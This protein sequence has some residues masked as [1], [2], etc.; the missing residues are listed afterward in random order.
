M[1]IAIF[2]LKYSPNLG[3]GIIA[4]CLAH[5]LEAALP[6]ASVVP[7]DLAGRCDFVPEPDR[8]RA[9][10]L[11]VLQ[12]LPGSQRRLIVRRLLE[13]KIRDQLRPRWRETLASCD[14][15]V[16]GG[17]QLF[18]D[19]DLNFP[20]KLSAA[21][22]ECRNA[23]LPVA[24]FGVG[25]GNDWST[26][27]RRLL[28]SVLSS[29]VIYAGVRDHDSRENLARLA[30]W[31]SCPSIELSPDPGLMAARVYPPRLREPRSRAVIGLGVTHPAILRYHSEKPV[32]WRMSMIA[33][34]YAALAK[35]LVEAGH[36]VACFCNG[37]SEDDE[38]LA[39]VR[40]RLDPRAINKGRVSF[41]PR[42]LRPC[43]LARIIS[44]VDVV[45]SHRLHASI[46][47]FAFRKPHI[48]FA[49]DR[50]VQ[51]FYGFV[52]RHG[53]HVPFI[54]TPD[55][56]LVALV[57]KALASGIDASTHARVIEQTRAGIGAL[58]DALRSVVASRSTPQAT[59]HAMR[60]GVEHASGQQR[61]ELLDAAASRGAQRHRE[62]CEGRRASNGVTV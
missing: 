44:D 9:W 12:A 37:A 33:E 19:A 54:E 11:K 38:Y 36:D 47:G 51:A 30:A 4:E 46:L 15:A 59:P 56:V 43:D 1:R 10:A 29:D 17:G 23:G 40:R 21:A 52:E 28:A 42:P 48:G 39:V 2:G 50:K 24:I 34:R 20:L 3:D 57:E 32:A 49:W 22:A 16:I 7:V 27:G 61:D 8:A 5:E 6:G 62:G 35:A 60:D 53:Y 45:V 31:G 55:D 26:E 13:P 14:A 58:A 41:S 25:V 18:A